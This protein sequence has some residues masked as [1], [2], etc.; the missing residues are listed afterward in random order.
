MVKI[1]SGLQ[2]AC[3]GTVPVSGEPH[4]DFQ[5]CGESFVYVLQP[6]RTCIGLFSQL[7]D[8]NC[9][10]I[11]TFCSQ[12]GLVS[13]LLS[14]AR[15]CGS[16]VSRR[17]LARL[18]TRSDHRLDRGA[19][20]GGSQLAAARGSTRGGPALHR[21]SSANSRGAPRLTPDPVLL[22]SYGALLR[23]E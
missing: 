9:D 14:A 17:F 22:F 20:Q 5:S 16:S 4:S 23:M 19:A 12:T 8:S 3:G 13:F 6:D 18:T 2:G 11:V 21:S 15:R 7:R 10:T 1:P